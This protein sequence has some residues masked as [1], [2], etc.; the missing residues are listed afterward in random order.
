MKAR[1]RKKRGPI[2]TKKEKIKRLERMMRAL[3]RS[4]TAANSQID[5]M[6]RQLNH[7]RRANEEMASF[8]REQ[9]TKRTLQDMRTARMIEQF[10]AH[11]K[12]RG[13]AES[14][15]ALGSINAD[16]KTFNPLFTPVH[17]LADRQPSLLQA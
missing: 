7:A 10:V 3:R 13:D 6:Q 4:L 14:T 12:Q 11:L 16:A 8:N 5:S 1:N 9:E 15:R 2:F 17:Q